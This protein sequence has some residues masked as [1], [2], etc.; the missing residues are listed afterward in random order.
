MIAVAMQPE[1]VI[2]ASSGSPFAIASVC[3][4]SETWSI[5]P[6]TAATVPSSCA[7]ARAS[8]AAES[9]AP[10]DSTP[11]ISASRPARVAISAAFPRT[12]ATSSSVR[13]RRAVSVR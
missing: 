4:P 10:I 1:P 8:S 12:T 6:V 2:V 5:G 3:S 9:L 11:R 7:A 13:S